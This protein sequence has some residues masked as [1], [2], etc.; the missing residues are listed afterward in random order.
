[1]L[2]GCLP[3]GCLQ[4]AQCSVS[5]ALQ[6]CLRTCTPAAAPH[7]FRQRQTSQNRPAAS[8]SLPPLTLQLHPGAFEEAAAG[9]LQ[10]TS[11]M[12]P[13]YDHSYFTIATFIDDHIAFHA[14][15]LLAA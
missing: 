2:A 4:A 1:L 13:G 15:H 12:Q 7:F 3:G 6:C 10:L 11:R 8:P 9:K 14:K 5:L